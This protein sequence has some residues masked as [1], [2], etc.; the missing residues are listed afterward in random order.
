[1]KRTK[2]KTNAEEEKT[3]KWTASE[4]E[5]LRAAVKAYGAKNWK[6]IAQDLPGRTDVQCLHRW[7]KV[8]HPGIIKGPWTKEEDETVLNCIRGGIKKWSEI[9][10]Y[11]PGRIG[12]QCRE[13]YFNHLDPSIRK[14]SWT[15]SEDAI[16]YEA[17]AQYGNKWSL[18]AKL[19]PGRTENS[20]KNRWNSAMRRKKKKPRLARMRESSDLQN[21]SS[22]TYSSQ[23]SK[24]T[25]DF[26]SISPKQKCTNT[27]GDTSVVEVANFMTSMM[28]NMDKHLKKDFQSKKAENITPKWEHELA[29][30]MLILSE[31]VKSE[32]PNH[33]TT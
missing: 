9:A 28:S 4:D 24:S 18:I 29:S 17:Q 12:K 16:L 22:K 2:R 15:E 5:A 30:T 14:G 23:D 7:Q 13:R 26:N 31:K 20:I 19:L 25:T 11:V 3:K 10:T 1:M 33:S 32:C 8:L 27:H 21:S 6:R